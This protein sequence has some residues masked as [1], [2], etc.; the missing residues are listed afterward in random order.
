MNE[1]NI[2]ET[3]E[4]YCDWEEMTDPI[5]DEEG[6]ETESESYIRI[7]NLYVKPEFRGQG[8]AKSLLSASIALIEK[9]YPSKEIRIVPE[10]K[11]KS[12][13]FDRLAKFYESMRLTVV[14]Y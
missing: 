11:E 5:L 13:D 10:P 12:V 1:N 3:K 2:I 6:S 4:G 14:A 7:N 9:A 8:F